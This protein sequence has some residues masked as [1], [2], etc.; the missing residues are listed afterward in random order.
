MTESYPLYKKIGLVA[1][2]AF[3]GLV[4][5]APTPEGMN[6]EARRAA[7]VA[8]LMAIWWITEAVPIAAASLL[9]I[10]LYPLLNVLSGPEVTKAYGD[11]NIFLFAGGFFIAMAMQKWNLHERIALAIISR[12]GT[13]PSRL[14][15]GF[16][17]GTG[18]ISMWMSNTATAVM[19]LP[20]AIAIID[21]MEKRDYP[22]VKNF[23]TALLLSI[24]YAASIGGMG[25]PI[26]SPPNGILLTNYTG[27]FPGAP[28]ITFV[29]WMMVGVPIV[30]IML[31]LTWL[32]LT[33][34]LFN[35]KAVSFPAA[36]DEIRGRLV[37][38]G[39]MGRGEI[40]V[41]C[42][43]GL[44]ALAW[45]FREDLVLGAF[46]L[47]GW[48]RVLGQPKW[49]NDGTIAI[50]GALLL[51]VIPVNLRKGEFALDWDWAKRIPWEVLL[52]F[53]G[54]LAMAEAFRST[55]LVEWVGTKFTLLEGV[56]P[57]FI[58]LIVSAFL[59]FSGEVTSNTA[60]AAIMMPILGAIA[61]ELGIH[62]LL[63]M[64]PAGM[65]ISC[66]VMLPAAT[67]PNAIVFGAGRITV[68]QMVRAGFLVDLLGVLV[69]T[70][71]MYLVGVYVFGI[72]PGVLPEWAA[73]LP[74]AAP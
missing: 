12:T 55:G 7:A 20:I 25:T 11:S 58:V 64:F 19:M 45:I 16:M 31:P 63:L 1:G 38:L 30:F 72:E 32:L 23:A 51:F 67:P 29:Q 73:P 57:L 61:P 35:F 42:V 54:G 18:F 10:A 33:R 52:L 39:R 34:V 41:L 2:L 49:I 14:V 60:T 5:L 66:G 50:I 74:P 44:T 40:I 59:A 46:T 53:G 4:L 56:P 48:T 36:R 47:P 15:L 28:P 26:G 17:L 69:V 6:P 37:E 70:T 9:P 8:A 24:A 65:A 21:Q 43:W 68:P 22:G 3:F 27:R 62:P 71:M 13:N